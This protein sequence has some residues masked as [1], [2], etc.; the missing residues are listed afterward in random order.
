MHPADRVADGALGGRR[1]LSGPVICNG[2]Q[3]Q[4]VC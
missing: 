1:V 4:G 3:C 2:L